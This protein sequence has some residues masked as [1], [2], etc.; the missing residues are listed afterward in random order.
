[1]WLGSQENTLLSSRIISRGCQ[2]T[3]SPGRHTSRNL[4]ETADGFDA[5][6]DCGRGRTE[7]GHL[8]KSLIGCME[9]IAIAMQ[10]GGTGAGARHE[11]AARPRGQPHFC[12]ATE[13]LCGPPRGGLFGN[14]LAGRHTS[15]NLLS[16]VHSIASAAAR[17]RQLLGHGG[18]DERDNLRRQGSLA[19]TS[20]S[21]AGLLLWSRVGAL[22]SGL[23]QE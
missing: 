6:S 11:A 23:R 3:F 22:L 10:D 17:H 14:L 13:R 5:D 12:L 9:R 4:L 18:R 16:R 19:H 15:R 1:M 21:W 2:G 8:Q 7:Q 20:F